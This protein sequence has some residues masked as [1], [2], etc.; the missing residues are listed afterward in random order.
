MCLVEGC[1]ELGHVVS[2]IQEKVP[3]LDAKALYLP[4]N[5]DRPENC[6]KDRVMVCRGCGHTWVAEERCKK[7]ECPRCYEIWAYLQGKKASFRLW[8]GRELIYKSKRARIL[9]YI[10]SFPKDTV[11]YL[12][13]LQQYRDEVYRVLKEHGIAGG[14]VTFHP[15]RDE[16]EPGHYD[17]EGAHFHCVGIAPGNVTPGGTDGDVVFKVCKNKKTGYSGYRRVRDI[18]S[19]VKYE[20]SHCGISDKTHGLTW[21]GVMSYNMLPCARLK[22]EC[23]EGYNEIYEIK[24]GKW[25]K[26]PR[27]GSTDIHPAVMRDVTN[28]Y[29]WSPWVTWDKG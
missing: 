8:M 27:C 24:K 2:C 18:T 20:L 9:E 4:G 1:S 22:V 23:E 17:V 6:G 11:I 5:G 10:V 19:K 28:G 16:N 7:R 21:F 25:G 3:S 12:D 26:C 15:Y 14:C 29:K 13:N